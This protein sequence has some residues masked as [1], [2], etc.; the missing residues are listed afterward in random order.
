MTAVAGNRLR[1]LIHQFSICLRLR[2]AYTNVAG[3]RSES[4]FEVELIGQH[5]CIVQHV[6]GGRPHSAR[7][8]P[9]CQVRRG[10]LCFPN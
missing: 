3:E 1:D 4:G 5:Y 2:P 9:Q 8:E 10:R 6:N 7:K